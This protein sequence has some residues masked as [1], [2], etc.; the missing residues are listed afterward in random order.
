MRAQ[1]LL[2]FGDNLSNPEHASTGSTDDHEVQP[3][4]R[5]PL[6]GTAVRSRIAPISQPF[7]E[8][9]TGAFDKDLAR[10][11]R[12]ASDSATCDLLGSVSLRLVPAV[13]A[14]QLEINAARR[15]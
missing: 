11:V 4:L 6:N 3:L 15:P 10:P 9:L 1:K 5:R 13:G 14:G 2:R 12:D 8:F 7:S